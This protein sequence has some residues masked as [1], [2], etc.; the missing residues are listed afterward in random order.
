MPE[1]QFCPSPRELDDL[2]LLLN[3][4]LDPLRTF[5]DDGPVRI[6]LP[7]P[8]RGAGSVDLVDPE[9]LPLARLTPEGLTAL[10]RPSHTHLD[11]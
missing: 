7:G 2:E 3:G 1:S 11:K 4:G 10:S 8:L 9:G 5:E 6:A